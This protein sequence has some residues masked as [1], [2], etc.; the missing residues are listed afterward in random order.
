MNWNDY[1]NFSKE[2]FDCSHTLKNEMKKE[3]LDLL[4]EVRNKSSFPFVITSGYRHPTHP[5]EAR[6]SK[7]GEH[8]YGMACDIG[9]YGSKAHELI[10]IAVEVG[11]PRIGVNQKGPLDE[12]FI[13]LGIANESD[14]FPSPWIWSY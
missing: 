10:K 4:Q 1:P 6:K 8:T 2:E 9:V 12:R 11:F 13:H 3:F 7:P 14:G 5:I